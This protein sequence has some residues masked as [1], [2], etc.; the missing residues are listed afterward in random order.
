MKR[1]NGTNV[2]Q[3]NVR[4]LLYDVKIAVDELFF[5]NEMKASDQLFDLW[6]IIFLKLHSFVVS[7][8]H[9]N[10]NSVSDIIKQPILETRCVFVN[11]LKTAFVLLLYEILYK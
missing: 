2:Q 7:V 9:S 4:H 3:Q 1:F 11:E 10:S 6:T 5:A 8:A